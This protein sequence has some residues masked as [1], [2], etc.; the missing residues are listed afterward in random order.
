MKVV[1][2]II[3]SPF[4]MRVHPIEKTKKMHSGV[5]VSAPIGT[6]VYCP[7]A[8]QVVVR[9]MSPSAGNF[10]HIQCGALTFIFMHLSAFSVSQAQ[11][12]VK[13]QKVGLVGMTGIATGPHLH[14]EVRVNGIAV[15]PE[16]YINF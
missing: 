15:N 2:G 14:F 8:G 9:G 3:T 11:M 13:G 10:L 6:P 16:I 5:D 1:E 4:G 12:V 7:E